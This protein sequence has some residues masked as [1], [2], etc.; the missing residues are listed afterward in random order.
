MKNSKKKEIVFLRF[1]YDIKQLPIWWYHERDCDQNACNKKS[2]FKT[3]RNAVSKN[4]LLFRVLSKHDRYIY[5]RIRTSYYELSN[6][7]SL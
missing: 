1:L 2:I 3:G 4:S 5:L 6:R 7:E